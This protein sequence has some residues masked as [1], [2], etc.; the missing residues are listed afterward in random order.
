MRFRDRCIYQIGKKTGISIGEREAEDFLE[1]GKRSTEIPQEEY[2]GLEGIREALEFVEKKAAKQAELTEELLRKIHCLLVYRQI[3]ECAGVYRTGILEG[4]ES[5]YSAVKGEELAYYLEHFFNQAQIS[6][7]LFSPE[8][9]AVICHKRILDLC[10]F[11]KQNARVALLVLN[12][13]SLE[14]GGGLL[15][16]PEALWSAYEEGLFLAKQGEFPDTAL[17]E[18][19]IAKARE[20][21]EKR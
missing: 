5:R 15:S 17:L 1:R 4:E 12:L 16:I 13:L 20:S 21:M 8:E 3:P 2:D 11:E 19:V 6:R 10:P 7:K 14:G 9:Y 18:Q